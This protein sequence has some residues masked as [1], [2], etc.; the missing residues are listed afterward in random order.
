LG[1]EAALDVRRM[2]KLLYQVLDEPEEALIRDLGGD[3]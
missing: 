3:I 1:T 2:G